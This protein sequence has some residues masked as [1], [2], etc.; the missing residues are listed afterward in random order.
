MVHTSRPPIAAPIH[1]EPRIRVEKLV[2]IKLLLFAQKLLQIIPRHS[3]Q[4]VNDLTML[5]IRARPCLRPIP[6][7]LRAV[8]SS[9][10]AK[11]IVK[12]SD[13]TP[14]PTSISESLASETTSPSS[15]ASPYIVAPIPEWDRGGRTQKGS[16]TPLYASMRRI[17][18][19]NP[20]C[21]C[22]VQVGSFYE[23]YFEQA[24]NF[25]PQLN[26]KV[27]TRKTSNF[28][29]P[30]AGFPLFQ[31]QKFV[32][33]LVQDL[34]VN[35]AIID[36]YPDTVR[37]SDSI[38]HRKIS[39]IIT[40][41]TLVD[42]I[43]M[44]YNENNYLAAIQFPTNYTSAP[45]DPDSPIGL[46]WIDISVGEFYVQNTTLGDLVTDISRINPSEIILPKDIQK[47]DIVSGKWYPPLQDLRKY[48]VRYHKTVYKDQKLQ[49]KSD[50]RATRKKIESFSVREEAAMNMIL[51]YVSVNLPDSNPS[52]DIP[53]QYFNNKCLQMDSRTREALELTERLTGNST[54]VVGSLLTTIRRTVSP[55]GNR[56]LTQW[57]ESPVLDIDELRER[58]S[59]VA[60]FL[61][62][63]F[64]CI[65]LRSHLGKTGDFIRSIQRLSFNNADYVSQLQIVS[66][67]LVK[68]QAIQDFLNEQ[69]L[70]LDSPE[71]MEFM[72]SFK[73]PI[74]IANEIQNTLHVSSFEESLESEEVDE[75]SLNEVTNEEY[76]MEYSTPNSYSNKGAE[77]YRD[78][79]VL[80]PEPFFQFAVRR[81]F[82]NKLKLL[83]DEFDELK[84]KETEVVE[85]LKK[86]LDF[87]PKLKIIKK[88]QH[89]RLTNVIHV[90]GKKKLIDYIYEN[91]HNDVR[92][93]RQASLLYQPSTW[94]KLQSGL[95]EKTE[96]IHQIEREIIL[97]LR[98][99][100]LLQ[101]PQIR[102]VSK[103][104][105]Y[106]DVTSSFA[107]LAKE[108]NL[109]RPRLVKTPQLNIV[110]GRHIVVETS[111]KS[112][113][114]MFIPNDTKVGSD[115]N[116]W[117]ISGPNMGGK[118]TYLRQ[119]ALIV[120]LAQ[121]GCFVPASSASI[122][123]V[124]R[125]FTR[126][127][128]SDD[129]FSDLSTFMVEMVETS[130]ILKN[131][132]PRSLAIVD[133]IGRG[134]SG[135][136]G[137]A[138]AFAT[139]VNLLT[140][141]KCRTLFAT[142]FG[143]ELSYLLSVDNVDQ[144]KIRYFRTRVAQNDDLGFIIDHTL[145]PGISERSY[146]FEVAK[147]AGFPEHALQLAAR[148][149][150]LLEQNN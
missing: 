78:K 112:T 47:D 52:I 41:G 46:S 62:N 45:P 77:K 138:I 16:L 116:L 84:Q 11:R 25:G 118:S 7:Q 93:K 110:N 40:P 36:Q 146:A 79:E 143:K 130:N 107:V 147:M 13:S 135:K 48:F 1:L 125:I 4:L 81:D 5:V 65:L 89:G 134:T 61:K 75:E 102:A 136:E 117:I 6:R 60:L 133:E 128:A 54:S 29:I 20:G 100:V 67:G 34:E 124:D 32:K 86:Q 31:L 94:S 63:E 21:V 55:S 56:L 97:L 23:L 150:K 39:R 33:M 27:A 106:L 144:D 104:A 30:M 57:I 59:F 58:Q 83:H 92:E 99:K 71:L 119:N 87:D 96:M 68:L 82:N 121:I 139:L 35:V 91:F 108:N 2:Q 103:L 10:R 24:E 132:T 3:L 145:E 22:L 90:S 85:N 66:E 111:L 80:Q 49:F 37:T 19:A 8:A 26:L 28:S 42:E 9:S 64:L 101:V 105:D 69:A 43:F 126:I 95:I 53:Q 15:L 131:A 123:I 142:H 38:I 127:G 14:F 17:I 12:K 44:N 98:D 70:K 74:D 122:G 129:L 113:G 88:A 72:K 140:V 120:I 141:N 18:D 137:L 51:S 76:S 115:G 114:E 50:I 109:V 148:A 73:V 149:L